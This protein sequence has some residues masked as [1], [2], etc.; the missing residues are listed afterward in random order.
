YKNVNDNR[1]YLVYSEWESI[2]TF[3]KFM[4]SRQFTQTTE[5]GKIILEGLPRHKILKEINEK[6][7]IIFYNFFSKKLNTTLKTL[8]KQ[9]KGLILVE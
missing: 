1:E 6:G 7:K 3:K 5:Y 8:S 2:E 9:R 4:L